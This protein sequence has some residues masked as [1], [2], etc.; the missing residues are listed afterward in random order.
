VHLR[1]LYLMG[2][3]LSR[4]RISQ[5][6]I[7]RLPCLSPPYPNCVPLPGASRGNSTLEAQKF[8][9]VT[10]AWRL[11]H[12]RQPLFCILWEVSRHKITERLMR[13]KC[14]T[15]RW[16]FGYQKRTGAPLTL[17]RSNF[18]KLDPA[19]ETFTNFRA[20]CPAVIFKS[21]AFS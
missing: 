4:V 16:Y 10:K 12:A 5:A 9:H 15:Q 2:V 20:S 1:C 7:L 21:R 13:A 18:R 8:S 17:T 3:A 14:N 6:C 19:N 11:Q